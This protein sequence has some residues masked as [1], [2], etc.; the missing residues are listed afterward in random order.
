MEQNLFECISCGHF[1]PFGLNTRPRCA[2]CGGLT[3]IVNNDTESPRFRP[4][5]GSRPDFPPAHDAQD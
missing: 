2:K 4:R 5:L 1:T 3:G